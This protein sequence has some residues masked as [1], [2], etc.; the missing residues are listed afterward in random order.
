MV[1]PGTA[2]ALAALSLALVASAALGGC[3]ALGLTEDEGAASPVA[4][5]GGG[6][7]SDGRV[8]VAAAFYPLAWVA[9]RV[10]GDR[11]AVTQLTSPGAEPH[12]LELTV[13][14]TAEVAR[15]DLVLFLGGFQP[16]VDD[17]VEQ[18]TRGTPLDAGDVVTQRSLGRGEKDPHFWLDPRKTAAVAEAA[19][20][21][22]GEIDRDHAAAY[23]AR[24]R[25]LT[26]ELGALDEAYADGLDDCARDTVVVNHDAFGYL[27]RY[28]LT[29]EPITGLSPDAEPTPGDLARLGDLARAQGVTTVF[30]ERLV[31]ARTARALADDLG[32]RADVLD[33]IE[34]RSAQTADEDYLSLMRANLAA[35][36]RANGC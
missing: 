11:V 4:A 31:S 25:A 3:A 1:R 20:G 24:A 33:P 10:G 34:G 13:G 35:L 16:A 26:R 2:R 15:A 7:L 8:S 22:L 23:A 21:A 17:A 9:E 27:S 29:F 18:G 6:S 36:V 28:G 12:D 19:A 32:L 30:S 5:G 14:E